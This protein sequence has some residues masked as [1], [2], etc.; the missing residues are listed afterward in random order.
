MIKYC[1]HIALLIFL[2]LPHEGVSQKK[3]ALVGFSINK[4][5]DTEGLGKGAQANA[6]LLSSLTN[7]VDDPEFRLDP[8]LKDFKTRFFNEFAPQFPFE[9]LSED[10]VINNAAYKSYIPASEKGKL[11]W[12]KERATLEKRLDTATMA[13]KALTKARIQENDKKYSSSYLSIDGYKTLRMSRF[14]KTVSPDLDQMLQIFEE[15][16][17]GIM[18]VE[19]HYSFAPIGVGVIVA[20]RVKCWISMR[21]WNTQGKQKR[22]FHI[23]EE[24]SSKDVIPAPGGIPIVKTEKLLKLCKQASDKLLEDLSK[25]GKMKKIIKK[26]AKK[27]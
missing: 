2:A 17:D 1:V 26:A 11:E 8:I 10:K 23:L 3:A 24:G 20:A 18:D 16:A 6:K 5:I 22:V 27:F 19:L 15:E 25:K 9:V 14:L 12:K 13:G 7:L 4:K 21:L